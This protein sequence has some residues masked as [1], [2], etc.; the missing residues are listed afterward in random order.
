MSAFDTHDSPL[1]IG[2]QFL[3]YDILNVIGRGGFA[4]VFRAHDPFMSRD[5]AIKIL[6]RIGGVTDDMQRRGQ[7]EAKLLG[8]LRHPHIVE[9]YDGGFSD[10]NLLYIVMEL[11][12]GRPLVA[13]L[14][15]FGKLTLPE[16]LPLF[17]ELADAFSAAHQQGAIHR[18][19]K[20]ENIFVVE[21]NHAKV[22]DFGIAKITEA[23]G[24][25]TTN[26]GLMIG[27]MKYMSPEQVQGHRV[28]PSSDIYALGLVMY[29]AFSGIH[30][31][32]VNTQDDG[33][34]ALAYKQV[35]EIPPS[36]DS[37]APGVPRDL[38]RLV[39]RCI[40]KKT[41]DRFQSMAE[42]GHA[43]R[44]CWDRVQRELGAA[45]EPP[46]DLAGRANANANAPFV[47]VQSDRRV[48]AQAKPEPPTNRVE[49]RMAE[50]AKEQAAMPALPSPGESN[51][52]NEEGNP[53]VTPKPKPTAPQ[54]RT[55][56]AAPPVSR[57]VPARRP[58][59]TARQRQR[60]T[61]MALFV[62]I[63]S[64]ALCGSLAFGFGTHW[65]V[66]RRATGAALHGVTSAAV[67]Q[68]A[69]TTFAPAQSTAA[70]T[71]GSNP[72]SPSAPTTAA[73]VKPMNRSNNKPSATRS[74]PFKKENSVT[75]WDVDAAIFQSKH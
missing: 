14:Q 52:Q 49:P 64:G 5:V 15:S 38:A 51:P 19:I 55:P 33:F 7:A 16:G 28:T 72:L 71:P 34:R 9:V 65:Y 30:P 59:Q 67:P 40:S 48:L 3:K 36:L 43:L 25:Q 73:A 12:L 6:H 61:K 57:S 58:R 60:P 11:L 20:P 63:M 44:N 37:I 46:R 50:E 27:T 62:A 2:A 22:L 39:D 18:D 45:L 70:M 54:S 13:C 17:I 8:R 32:M 47:A 31:C 1:K 66:K 21:G 75:T 42:L 4:W 24:L 29:E 10:Q 35:V 23:G 68:V 41:S 26:Q 69:L 74:K 56:S 53:V